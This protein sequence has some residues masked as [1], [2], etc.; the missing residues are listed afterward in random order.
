VAE[1][2]DVIAPVSYTTLPSRSH[3]IRP[4]GIIYLLGVWLLIGPQLALL[5]V[6]AVAT[7][8]KLVNPATEFTLGESLTNVIGTGDAVGETGK[9]LIC[10]L[11]IGVFV[12]IL[13]KAHQ[14]IRTRQWD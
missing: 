14:N 3:G 1:P 5:C 10:L 11:L 2:Q 12:Y 6:V 9:L 8:V 4:K 13:R 7:V